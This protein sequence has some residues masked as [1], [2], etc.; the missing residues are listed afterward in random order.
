MPGE[1]S[2]GKPTARRYTDIEKAQAVRS[3][4]ELRKEP[5]TEISGHEL[6][7]QLVS[8]PDEQG[9]QFIKLVTSRPTT[10][11][12]LR[13]G[14]ASRSRTPRMRAS[15]PFTSSSMCRA[16]YEVSKSSDGKF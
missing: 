13:A 11:P 1:K 5:G 8:D 16:T 14:A 10:R 12:I 2:P 7:D 6:G 9:G 15:Q 3:V 4:R